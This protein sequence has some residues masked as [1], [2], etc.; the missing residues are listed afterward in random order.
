M[1][2][3]SPTLPT[4]ATAPSSTARSSDGF[5]DRLIFNA[6]QPALVPWLRI[7]FAVLAAINTLVWMRDGGY[8]FSNDGVL[9]TDTAIEINRHARWSLLF[10]LPGSPQLVQ[11]CLTLLLLHCLCLAL[12]LWS[13]IQMVCIFVWLVSFQNRNPIICDAEDTLFRCFA[14]AMI[15]LPLDC[16]YS[17]SRAWRR[18]RGRLMDIQLRDTWAVS[19]MQFQMTVIYLSAAW[20]KCWG[21]TWQDGT[22][23]YYVSHMTDLFGRM[24][25]LTT[26][27]DQLWLVRL[28]TWGVVVIE[29]LLPV[30]LWI[31]RTRR[32][33]VALGIALHLG[34]ELTMNL[35]LFEWLMILGL[36]SF[37]GRNAERS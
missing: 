32:W 16:G 27:F 23:L 30:F 11:G 14:F 28:M 25:A 19:L 7:G 13:R 34:I 10:T 33:G 2:N 9:T 24:P 4:Q 29:G 15:F 37:L 21:N 18:R 3:S 36:V 35:F 17:L 26:L 22:A 31:P 12:G 20:S 6:C 8:W 5:I 1:S